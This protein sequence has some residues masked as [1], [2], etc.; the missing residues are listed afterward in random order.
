V[1]ADYFRLSAGA[2]RNRG[3]RSWLTVIGTLIGITA[4]VSLVSIGQGLERSVENE[5]LELGGN[6]L[7]ITPGGGP[8]SGFTDSSFGIG[9]DELETVRGVN[10]IDTA[11]GGLSGAVRA[12]FRE[13]RE[14]VELRGLP[15][16]RNLREAKE[17]FGLETVSGRYLSSGDT[18]SVVVESEEAENLFEDEVILR[19]DVALNGTDFNVVGKIETSDSIGNFQ[20]FAMPIDKAREVLDREEG[21]D[22]IFAEALAGSEVPEVKSDVARELRNLRGSEKGEESFRIQ[23]AQDIIESFQSQLSIIRSVLLGIGAISL[24]VGAVGIMNTMYSSVIEREKDIGVMK[25][26]GATRKQILLLFT[27]ESG[28]VGFVG[29]LMGAGLGL[30]ISWLAGALIRSSLPLPY[31]PYIS[32]GLIAG[33]VAFSFV[34]GMISGLLPAYKASRKRPVEALSDDS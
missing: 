1:I 10:G 26:V 7:F 28:M 34:V 24:L 19:S 25:A 8:A 20:G 32:P 14:L 29:G 6:K 3:K 21:F 13:D 31:S 4:V 16:G 5:L 23:T 2:L 30:A 27:V 22:I 18:S 9:Q 12:E 15:T 17:V 33:A 11:V